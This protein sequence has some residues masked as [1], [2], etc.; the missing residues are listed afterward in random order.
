MSTTSDLDVPPP[1]P[2]N[3]SSLMSTVTFASDGMD[4]HV[5]V[6]ARAMS[7]VPRT[8][9]RVPRTSTEEPDYLG[10]VLDEMQIQ[11]LANQID[12]LQKKMDESKRVKNDTSSSSH[13][14]NPMS[15][16]GNVIPVRGTKSTSPRAIKL[17][18]TVLAEPLRK[19]RPS[20]SRGRSTIGTQ[21]YSRRW[22]AWLAHAAFHHDRN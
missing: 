8:D 6:P 20:T 19:Q 7:E 14:R 21:T 18:N 13:H 4:T 10:D 9:S 15:A 5:S 17:G 12:K 22:S 11:Q 3:E 2:T 16:A 1:V